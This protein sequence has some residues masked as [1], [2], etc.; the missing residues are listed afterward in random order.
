MC[1]QALVT[2]FVTAVAGRPEAGAADEALRRVAI[3]RVA[4]CHAG[5]QDLARLRSVLQKK[6]TSATKRE[7]APGE[8]QR[9]LVCFAILRECTTR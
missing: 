7:F 4:I 6:E 3:C 8:A 9:H 5:S 2:I 1:R